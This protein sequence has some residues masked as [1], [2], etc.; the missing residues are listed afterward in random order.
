[1]TLQEFL[2]EGDR[3]AHTSGIRITELRPGYCRAEMTVEPRHLNGGGVCQG[4]ALFTLGDLALAGCSNAHGKLCLSI[5]SQIHFVRSATLGEHLKAESTEQHL[6][7]VPLIETR[8]T[9]DEGALIAL[10]TSQCF[11]KDTPIPPEDSE[12]NR[13]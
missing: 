10:M 11:R 6:G 3:F 4:G 8:I 7:K 1:M 12:A 13:P 5:N 2:N 9:N